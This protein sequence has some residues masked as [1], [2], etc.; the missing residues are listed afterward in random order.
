M[1]TKT[2]K[3]GNV[4]V[5]QEVCRS[6]NL[7]GAV[8]RAREFE[9]VSL[10]L[11]RPLRRWPSQPQVA[12]IQASICRTSNVLTLSLTG[13]IIHVWTLLSIPNG[14]FISS[15]SGTSGKLEVYIYVSGTWYTGFGQRYLRIWYHTSIRY[16]DILYE[17]HG[18]CSH[19]SASDGVLVHKASHRPTSNR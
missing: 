16:P 1:S 5:A 7:T 9:R 3:G 6:A 4:N 13:N 17:A 15:Q 12:A 19:L 10:K 11:G 18:V 14:D 2:Q 8:E